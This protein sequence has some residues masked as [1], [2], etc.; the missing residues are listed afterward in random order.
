[1]NKVKKMNKVKEILIFFAA[2]VRRTAKSEDKVN[3]GVN[4]EL[5]A[6]LHLAEL[7]FVTVNFPSASPGGPI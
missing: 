4:A 6:K 3:T 7:G 5:G 1:M 2:L